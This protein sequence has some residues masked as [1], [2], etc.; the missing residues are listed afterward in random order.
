MKRLFVIY[1]AIFLS[2]CAFAF[3]GVDPAAVHKIVRAEL[4]AM[5][6]PINSP[7]CLAILPARDTSET[8]A[9]PSPQLLGFLV[10]KGMQPRGA[11]SCN[12]PLPKGNLVS[13]EVVAESADGLSAKVTFTDVTITPDK[14]VGV[15]H[16]R[17]LY[18]LRRTPKGKW[19]IESY[20]D[21]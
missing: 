1:A 18:E 9:D 4:A 15:V 12:K 19:A 21:E 14:D 11:S 7:I 8:G 16:R 13:I 6:L 10:R 5:K 17:G 20:T 2:S 3:G